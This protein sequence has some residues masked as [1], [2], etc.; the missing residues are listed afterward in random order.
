MYILDLYLYRA[1]AIKKDR[2]R[3]PTYYAGFLVFVCYD[4]YISEIGVR[5]DI[6]FRNGVKNWQHSPRIMP[7]SVQGVYTIQTSKLSNNYWMQ[8]AIL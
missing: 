3:K 6:F 7:T 5:K 1:E 8:N 4:C 2:N